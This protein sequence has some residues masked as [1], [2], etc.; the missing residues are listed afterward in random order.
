MAAT[1]RESADPS[2]IAGL[3]QDG[4]EHQGVA[5]RDAAGRQNPP[6]GTAKRLALLYEEHVAEKGREERFLIAITYLATFLLVRFITHA[7][8]D[9]RF[10]F[11]FHNVSSSDGLH[12]HHFVFGILLLLA[13]GYFSIAFRPGPGR[14]RRL[15][16]A[17]FGAGA[18]LTLDEF[19]LW[20]R[21]KDV[22]WSPQGRE[23]IDAIIAVSVIVTVFA[24]G[25]DLF[26]AMGHD[27]VVIARDLL[28]SRQ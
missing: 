22:Y 24:T 8:K 16:G 26:K 6:P 14:V 17:L 12:I 9:H 4:R 11:L 28:G 15:C 25:R 1:D 27:V 3:Q 13:I 19:A 5:P 7:I 2:E 21:L 20:L 23:S 18:A 10:K